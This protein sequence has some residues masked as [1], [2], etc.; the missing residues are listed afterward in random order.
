MIALGEHG[1]VFVWRS[2]YKRI[3]IY[4]VIF[5]QILEIILQKIY[6]Q[7]AVL[8]I[9][10]TLSWFLVAFRYD[11]KKGWISDFVP[12]VLLNHPGARRWLGRRAGRLGWCVGRLDP[13]LLSTL[14]CSAPPRTPLSSSY[15][16][17]SAQKPPVCFAVSPLHTMF[18][19]PPSLS[20]G[21][22]HGRGSACKLCSRILIIPD[23][24]HLLAKGGKGR[25]ISF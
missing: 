12:R 7:E 9:I 18:L 2:L 24:K 3:V 13:P 8:L 16:H 20:G 19:L 14:L 15:L 4:G 6:F 22:L 5:C 25:E 11:L 23:T 10:P 21:H 1:Q 17:H